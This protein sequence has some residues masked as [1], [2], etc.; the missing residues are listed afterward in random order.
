MK[1]VSQ[2]ELSSP[3][4]LVLELSDLLKDKEGS[5][6]SIELAQ[7][8]NDPDIDCGCG[9][10]GGRAGEHQEGDK[11]GTGKGPAVPA[12]LCRLVGVRVLIFCKDNGCLRRGGIC[13]GQLIRPPAV[14]CVCV[15]RKG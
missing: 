9:H 11:P 4:E 8:E 7:E 14:R 5:L 3:E 15:R 6:W 13:I 10:S 2:T 1:I 12:P